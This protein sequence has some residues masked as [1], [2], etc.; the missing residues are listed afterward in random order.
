[1]AVSFIGGGNQRTQR[2]PI[3][4][5]KNKDFKKWILSPDLSNFETVYWEKNLIFI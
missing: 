3:F 2:K 5:L 1:V 4:Y